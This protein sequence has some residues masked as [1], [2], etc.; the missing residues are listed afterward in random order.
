MTIAVVS[1]TERVGNRF[2]HY[3]GIY[4][5][6]ASTRGRIRRVVTDEARRQNGHRGSQPAMTRAIAM[7]A[8]AKESA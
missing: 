6:R 5:A 8:D 3:C 4:P 7:R 1:T 2:Y